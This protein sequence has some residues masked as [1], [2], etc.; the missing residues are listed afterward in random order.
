MQLFKFSQAI[1]ETD[2]SVKYYFNYSAGG[3]EYSFAMTKQDIELRIFVLNG[4]PN[5]MATDVMKQMA[6]YSKALHAHPVA[7]MD[8]SADA[9]IAPALDIAS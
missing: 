1:Q 9:S 6:E 7:A 4:V 8:T 3:V 5:P 2:G